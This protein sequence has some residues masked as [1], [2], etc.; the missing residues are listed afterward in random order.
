[1]STKQFN[2][3]GQRIEELDPP[4]RKVEP[5]LKNSEP[6]LQKVDE[7]EILAWSEYYLHSKKIER[8][9]SHIHFSTKL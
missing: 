1:M 5:K 3:K 9:L 8:K 2:S 6:K 7:N 4:L